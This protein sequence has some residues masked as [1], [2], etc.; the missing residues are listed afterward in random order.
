[1]KAQCVCVCVC[2]FRSLSLFLFLLCFPFSVPLLLLLLLLLRS[3][4]SL[5]T[6]AA[7]AIFIQ[8][9]A[10]M[11]S[12]VDTDAVYDKACYAGV[13]SPCLSFVYFPHCL[14]SCHSTGLMD[15]HFFHTQTNTHTHIHTP[16]YTNTHTQTHTHTHTYTHT[17]TH[18]YKY[19]QTHINMLK[20]TNTRM[21]YTLKRRH[22]C[23]PHSSELSFT[24]R[25]HADS[26]LPGGS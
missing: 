23:T 15:G 9:P 13:I 26:H 12:A 4:S 18:T 16:T 24:R 21:L 7:E 3:L 25:P 20:P 22:T 14:F 19:T 5:L 6:T 2:A 1:M 17:Q 8:S 10:R 11:P